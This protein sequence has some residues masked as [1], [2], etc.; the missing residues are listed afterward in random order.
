MPSDIRLVT[1]QEGGAL[2]P[3]TKPPTHF[4]KNQP[5]HNPPGGQPTHQKKRLE[6]IGQNFSAD[7]TLPRGGGVQRSTQPLLKSPQSPHVLSES[8]PMLQ[9]KNLKLWCKIFFQLQCC[10]MLNLPLLV[11]RRRFAVQQGTYMDL[12][13][14]LGSI[15]RICM[16]QHFTV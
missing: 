5:T 1:P 8:M 14:E 4:F 7:R 3:R 9:K 6:K 11:W 10:Q 12:L 15:L 13:Q 2:F 16:E